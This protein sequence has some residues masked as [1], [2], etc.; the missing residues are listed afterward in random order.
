M[1]SHQSHSQ[2]KVLGGLLLG[3][4]IGAGAAYLLSNSGRPLRSKLGEMYLNVSEQAQDIAEELARRTGEVSEEVSNHFFDGEPRSQEN[5]NWLVGS[6]AA[7]VLGIT[8]LVLYNRRGEPSVRDKLLSNIHNFTKKSH[9]VANNIEES[10]R[11]VAENFEGRVSS[12]IDIAQRF[13]DNID[14]CAEKVC[15]KPNR[16]DSTIDKVVDW[17]AFGLRLYQ[18]FNESQKTRR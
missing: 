7:G 13:I 12:W 1:K 14:G 10:A 9:R 17:A 18:T 15:E 16:E 11:D 8:A 2:R 5:L 6:V 3:S 4:L